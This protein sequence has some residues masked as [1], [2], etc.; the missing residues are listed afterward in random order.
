MG[1]VYS[2]VNQKGGVGKTTSSVNLGAC[3][4]VA[5]KKVLLI[6][7]DPQGNA[8]GG[9]GLDKALYEE[10]N[11]YQGLIGA[12]PFSEIIY[13]TELPY[14]DICPADNNLTGAEI[15][16][17]SILSREAKLKNSLIESGIK[18]NMTT[19]SLIALQVLAF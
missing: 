16:L 17:V 12:V 4:A 6:D 15:E 18:K 2:I 10:K 19:S 1:M 13:P 8:S 9:L 14:L 3:L 11:I 5:K 7:L